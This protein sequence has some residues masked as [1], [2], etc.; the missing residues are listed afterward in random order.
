MTLPIDIRGSGTS[1]AVFVGGRQVDTV[2]NAYDKACIKA[3]KIERRLQR[4][5]R[6]CLRC[7]TTFTAEHRHN[8]L[9][10]DCTAF[11]AGAT[12]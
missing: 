7:T 10:P 5:D 6:P 11:A 3:A 12:V 2:T 4:I 9:C 1:W 8:R